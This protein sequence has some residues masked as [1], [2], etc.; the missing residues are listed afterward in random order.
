MDVVMGL[1]VG[2][3]VGGLVCLA[4]S[5]WLDLE[6]RR[7]ERLV[8]EHDKSLSPKRQTARPR[9]RQLPHQGKQR[10]KDV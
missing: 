7:D 10:F 6:R 3:L 9:L 8:Q 2:V 4:T 5:L 1:T